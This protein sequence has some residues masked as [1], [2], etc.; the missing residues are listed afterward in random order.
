MHAC[1]GGRVFGALEQEYPHA[2]NILFLPEVP[3]CG[4]LEDQKQEKIKIKGET[5]WPL[6]LACN[7]GQK[8]TKIWRDRNTR[9]RT[10]MA[11]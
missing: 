5:V 10:R 1:I 2:W 4:T 8:R 3:N 11:M 9:N 6:Q 7:D